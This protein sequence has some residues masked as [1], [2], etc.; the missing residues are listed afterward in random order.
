MVD[1]LQRIYCDKQKCVFGPDIIRDPDQNH[2]I[3]HL[4]VKPKK[5]YFQR[6]LSKVDVK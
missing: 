6:H 1:V 3:K 2:F 4:I 5:A